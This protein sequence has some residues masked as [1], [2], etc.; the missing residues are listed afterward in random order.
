MNRKDQIKQVVRLE[1]VIERYFPLQ[2]EGSSEK[3]L[4]GLC[5]FH[6]DHHPSFHVNTKEQYYKCFACGDGG[7]VFKFVQGMEGC[8][9][10]KALKILAGWY[11]L[12]DTN[13]LSYIPVKKVSHVKPK[14]NRVVNQLY[15]DQ[16]LSNHR[17][18]LDLLE[19]YI[20]EEEILREAYKVFEVGV[21]PSALPTSYA[22]LC[23][24][25]I[26]P[27]RNEKGELVAF[28]GRYRGETKGIDIRKYINSCNSIIYHKGEL[29]YGLFQAQESIGKH[30]FVYITEGYKDVLAMYAAGFCNTVALCGTTLTEQHVTLLSRYTRHVV[31]MLDGDTAGLVSGLKSVRMLAG[32]GFSVSQIILESQ[33][34]PDSLLEAI[35]YKEFISYLK[36]RTR[37]S[38]LEAYEVDLLKQLEQVL[39]DL[40]LALTISE[41]NDLITRMV[42]LH[43]RLAKVTDRLMHSP[44]LRSKW[45][46]GNYA[47]IK[48]K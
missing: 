16:L 34:D 1:E 19:T 21:A 14:E 42:T 33:H 30:G 22:K 15:I 43:K 40:K 44:V 4:V 6:D 5:P 45:L 47:K 46:G 25:L 2:R 28:A 9:F 3:T 23:G 27:I 31:V 17:V 48:L 18:I 12:S 10:W 38:R 11:G 32:Q 29:L 39:S 13:D 36:L 24:R 26:F 20:P 7:D 8:D 41:R 37:F 35:G